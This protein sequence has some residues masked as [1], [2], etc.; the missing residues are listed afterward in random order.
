MQ[1]VIMLGK[2]FY[3]AYPQLGNELRRLG[4]DV[5]ELVDHDSPT[6]TA[7]VL[8]AVKRADIIV[9]GVERI[10]REVIDAA[11]NLKLIIKHGAGYDN[12]DVAYAKEKG[13]AVTFARGRNAGS[14]AELTM[15]LILAAARGIAYTN[16]RMRDGHW[17]LY[18]G[19]EV[20]GK[21]LGLV[22]FGAIGARVAR[23]AKAFGMW[24][25]VY[26]PFLS[27]EQI[28]AGGGEAAGLDRL[29]AES[30]YVSLHVPA[31]RE[32]VGLI[33]RDALAKMKKTAYLI[34]TSR[35]EIVDEDA[36][37]AALK[38]GVIK[39]AALDVFSTEPARP[40]IVD[41]PNV[42]ATPHIGGCSLGGARQL[43]LASLENV[44]RLLSGDEL[45]DRL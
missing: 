32:N 11:P 4:L 31:T 38:N 35:G 40:E 9:V 19:D 16:M 36:L 39:A 17:G 30:D 7:E 42:L 28:A 25:L 12:I 29:L 45:L 27:P 5:T 41:L 13:V 23:Y 21:T 22:G 37:I 33:D 1:A 26:D 8:P 2:S 24:I 10:S 34:N 20:E 14:V 15:G 44:R 3:A 6:P 18:M 43:C